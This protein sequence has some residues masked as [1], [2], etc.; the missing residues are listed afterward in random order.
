METPVDARLISRGPNGLNEEGGDKLP[1]NQN[2]CFEP[3]QIDTLDNRKKGPQKIKSMRKQ[4]NS[5]L[6]AKINATRHSNF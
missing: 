4:D 5:K 2:D 1:K 6:I 3:S